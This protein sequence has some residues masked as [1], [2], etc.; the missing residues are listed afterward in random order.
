MYSYACDLSWSVVGIPS[1]TP[2]ENMDFP[3]KKE[4][5]RK[6]AWIGKRENQRGISGNEKI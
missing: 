3:F 4:K 6:I 1:D 2:L 5:E